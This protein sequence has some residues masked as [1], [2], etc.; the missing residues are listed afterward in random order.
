[1]INYSGILV[2]GQCVSGICFGISHIYISGARTFEDC[3]KDLET[4][5]ERKRYEWTFNASK[6]EDFDDFKYEVLQ[7]MNLKWDLY[8]Q[9]KPIWGWAKT[10]VDNQFIN[11]LR[12]IYLGTASPCGNC[13]LAEGNEMCRAFSTQQNLN[14]PVFKKWYESNKRHKHSARMTLTMESPTRSQEVFA[15]PDTSFNIEKAANELHGKIQAV[16]TESEWAIYECLYIIGMTEEETGDK[17]NF[18]SNENGKGPGYRRIRAVKKTIKQ[19]VKDFIRD[20][21][22]DS[23]FI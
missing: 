17:L 9:T 3:Y 19:K 16:L 1:M 22:L 14:C 2:S 7:H 11:K 5:V 21:G 23:Q 18:K 15:I 10:L 6:M 12:N 13:K 4:I 20:E 8:D